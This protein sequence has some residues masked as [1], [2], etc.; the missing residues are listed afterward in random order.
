MAL[1]RIG[2]FQKKKA[3]DHG[4]EGGVGDVFHVLKISLPFQTKGDFLVH[5]VE[6]KKSE[7]A[8]DYRVM[9]DGFEVGAIWDAVSKEGKPYKSGRV[10]CVGAPDSELEFMIFPEVVAEGEEKKGQH[11]VFFEPKKQ[12]SSRTVSET[13]PT[14]D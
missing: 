1:T 13:A 4:A 9:H 12:K 3:A 10:V 6:E 8:P 7:N 14:F 11:P 2:T 5:K